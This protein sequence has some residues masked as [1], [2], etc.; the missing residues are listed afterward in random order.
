MEW[1]YLSNLCNQRKIMRAAGTKRKQLD[2][3]RTDEAIA[4]KWQ[5]SKRFGADQ[6]KQL[7]SGA[8]RVLIATRWNFDIDAVVWLLLM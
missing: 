8:N 4:T 7:K 5:S 6:E 1:G 3:R 2:Q